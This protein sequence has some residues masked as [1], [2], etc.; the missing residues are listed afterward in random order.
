MAMTIGFQNVQDYLSGFASLGTLSSSPHGAFWKFKI[1]SGAQQPITYD[2]FVNG[3]VPNVTY[4]GT[5]IPIIWKEAPLLSPL[6]LILAEPTGF[7]GKP[8]MMP[9]TALP[10]HLT[11]P[12]IAIPLPDGTNVPGT[13]VLADLEVWLKNGFPKDPKPIP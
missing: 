6:F 10:A 7:A 8:Q 11:D 1:V 13:Q 9:N 2:E 3:N 4:R 5:P 12:G